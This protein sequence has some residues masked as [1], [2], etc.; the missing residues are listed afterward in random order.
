MST[1]VAVAVPVAVAVAV[2]T[3]LQASA[4]TTRVKRPQR[5]GALVQQLMGAGAELH[6]PLSLT[7]LA[8]EALHICT[9]T[10]Q[11][12]AQL[13]TNASMQLN[14]D[15]VSDATVKSLNN[16]MI[17]VAGETKMK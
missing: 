1:A 3:C 17:S 12:P 14:T 7:T 10:L 15:D 16:K 2:A 9:P 4:V 13:E 11:A 6:R 8:V 5:E